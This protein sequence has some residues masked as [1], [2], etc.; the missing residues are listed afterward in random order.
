MNACRPLR[1]GDPDIRTNREASAPSTFRHAA[2][3]HEREPPSIVAASG[4]RCLAPK[5]RRHHPL[6]RADRPTGSDAAAG[7]PRV[8]VSAPGTAVERHRH[9]AA[10]QPSDPPMTSWQPVDTNVPLA[11]PCRSDGCGPSSHAG[12]PGDGRRPDRR[13][14]TG[15]GRSRN[16]S[17][18]WSSACCCW[19][20]SSSEPEWQR[21]PWAQLRHPVPANRLMATRLMGTRA[22]ADRWPAPR[23]APIAQRQRGGS[24]EHER[25]KRRVTAPTTQPSSS[26]TAHTASGLAYRTPASRRPAPSCI[27]RCSA[28]VGAPATVSTLGSGRSRVRLAVDRLRCRVPDL[29][30]K[31]HSERRGPCTDPGAHRA[32]ATVGSTSRAPIRSAL[33]GR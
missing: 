33:A 8:A 5:L 19:R 11:T 17:V 22:T 15:D 7:S 23:V 2:I 28:T 32:T 26:A 14:E 25:G 13:R 20:R 9:R 16:R 6:R 4:W 1:L 18:P 27:G 12:E 21:W 3:A 31:S 24:A 30:V 10:M 29:A